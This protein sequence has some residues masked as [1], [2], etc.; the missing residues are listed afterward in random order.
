MCGVF[1]F[2]SG[3]I[4][5]GFSLFVGI[6][7]MLGG[8]R[9]FLP[10][11]GRRHRL[12]GL[13]YFVWLICG[14]SDVAIRMMTGGDTQHDRSPQVYLAYDTILGILGS[15]LTWTAALDFGHE[16]VKV[17]LSTSSGALHPS[18]TISRSEMIEHL[19]YQILNLVQA[20]YLHT[21][22]AFDNN[23]WYWDCLLLFAVTS[24]WWFRGNF[25]IN[26]FSANYSKERKAAV[27]YSSLIGYLYQIKKYQYLFY[28]HFLLHG[29]NISIVLS[30]HLTFFPVGFE[31]MIP[32]SSRRVLA[33]CEV[34]W[35]LFWLC[36]NSSYTFEFFL[37]TLVKRR[38]LKQM[39]MLILNKSCMAAST[40]AALHVLRSVSIPC[41]G[42]SWM[43]NILHRHHEVGNMAF[44]V[45]AACAVSK[46]VTVLHWQ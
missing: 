30:R 2:G 8:R 25:P 33:P 12:C 3:A 41:A 13:V 20:V 39:T 7:V 14:F 17:P 43:L 32:S 36:L 44:V 46:V 42:L 24:V 38:H 6:V 19:F 21:I 9:L 34:R 29:L 28:K 40:V 1:L 4:M 10:A 16:K 27:G 37:Q 31:G 5:C 35:R 15:I 26:S 22:V 23:A 45:V 11:Y 18:A